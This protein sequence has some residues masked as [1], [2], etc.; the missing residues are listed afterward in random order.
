[1]SQTMFEDGYKHYRCG[2]REFVDKHSNLPASVFRDGVDQW[3]RL[4]EV[5]TGVAAN[6]NQEFLV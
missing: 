1:M 2:K 5:A 4:K 6:V 3:H